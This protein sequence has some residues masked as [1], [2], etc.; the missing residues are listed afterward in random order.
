[1]HTLIIIVLAYAAWWVAGT[2]SY[3]RLNRFWTPKYTTRRRWNV[4]LA[5]ILFGAMFCTVLGGWW[6]I[7]AAALFNALGMSALAEARKRA[8]EK[9]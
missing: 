6:A 7:L 3:K 1:M 5:V 4:V 9:Q 2:W 8:A